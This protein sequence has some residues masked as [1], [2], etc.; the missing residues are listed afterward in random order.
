M[1]RIMKRVMADIIVQQ[2]HNYCQNIVIK[3]RLMAI[4]GEQLMYL[5][6]YVIEGLHIQ[7]FA[8]LTC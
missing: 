2:K 3:N 7:I 8:S 1:Q 6:H 5:T 4:V